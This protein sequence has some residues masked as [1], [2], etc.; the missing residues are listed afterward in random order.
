MNATMDRPPVKPPRKQNPP[1]TVRPLIPKP[2]TYRKIFPLP[3]PET[4]RGVIE[5]HQDKIV[6]HRYGGPKRKEFTFHQ[7]WAVWKGTL[8]L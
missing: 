5:L 7:L 8:P 2:P 4:G 6:L 1:P 3:P